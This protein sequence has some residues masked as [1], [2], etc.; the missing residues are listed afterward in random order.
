MKTLTRFVLLVFVSVLAIPSSWAASNSLTDD[1]LL[2]YFAFEEG[3]WWD[4]VN[5][6]EYADDYDT[7]DL[8]IVDTE[9]EATDRVEALECTMVRCFTL[10][11]GQLYLD[12]Y[13]ENGSVYLYKYDGH[14]AGNIETFA[15]DG[16]T[17]NP[18]GDVRAY[19]MG[20]DNL[21]SYTSNLECEVDNGTSEFND[22]SG[23][24]LEQTCTTTLV[25]TNGDETRIVNTDTYL[26]GVG[27]IFSERKEYFNDEWQ[28]T[29]SVTLKDT[30]I[31]LE[32][33]EPVVEEDQEVEI[34]SEDE[35]LLDQNLQDY[36]AFDE[37]TWWEYQV[38]STFY[39]NGTS[40]STRT[41]EGG[42]EG[43]GLRGYI[44]DNV[45]Y[46]SS[47]NGEDFDEPYIGFDLNGYSESIGEDAY[48]ALSIDEEI[49]GDVENMTMAC[50]YSLDPSHEVEFDNGE[51][52]EDS[53]I[54]EECS[55]EFDLVDSGVNMETAS[56]AYYVKGIGMASSMVRIYA[57]GNLLGQVSQTLLSTS[58]FEDSTFSDLEVEDINF[59]A[60][61]YLYDEGVLAGYSDGT[62][63][64][65]NTVNRA[66]LLKILVEG[67]GVTPDENTYKNCFPDVTT[68]WYAK[69]VC[70]AK[71]KG[72]VGGYPDGTFRPAD[73][74]NK[75]EALKMLLN[76]QDIDTETPEE[77]PFTDV[78]TTD[79]FA[80]YVATAQSLDLLE[81]TGY[82]FSPDSDRSRAGIAEELYRLLTQL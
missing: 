23:D 57:S 63:K 66:E 69:Y 75:V 34:A 58:L 64:P 11:S 32:D 48:L 49:W 78:S 5:T 80:P 9:E 76:S 67:Q 40:S 38:D 2:E 43:L 31:D 70:Y 72:W 25:Y 30:S 33:L 81:E 16:F 65:D 52:V 10:S 62:F 79:W 8:S 3:T 44:D 4:Y 74:V 6:V 61:D 26:K 42:P 7:S 51:Q 28:V 21:N 17:E 46:Y 18:L 14:V 60:I 68:D 24:S 56:E 82:S 73:S 12:Y 1:E 15:L 55:L 39:F 35:E 41:V 13:I 22:Y 59:P 19:L 54:F 50:E 45:Y 77:K 71:E 47:Y 53:A 27:K 29:H 36:F 20:Y 37:G